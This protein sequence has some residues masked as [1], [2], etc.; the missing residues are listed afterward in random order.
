[1]SPFQRRSGASLS[2]K[3]L[4][5]YVTG[6][7]WRCKPLVAIPGSRPSRPCAPPAAPFFPMAGSV[8]VPPSPPSLLRFKLPYQH[9]QSWLTTGPSSTEQA[10]ARAV[11][12][13]AARHPRRRNSAT[14]VLHTEALY[15]SIRLPRTAVRYRYWYGKTPSLTYW[16]FTHLAP[17]PGFRR[18]P[19]VHPP[20]RARVARCIPFGGEV[21]YLKTIKNRIN[22]AMNLTCLGTIRRRKAEEEGQ[23]G[24]VR[25]YRRRRRR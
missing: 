11:R 22:W 1:M 20:S 21:Y 18:R 4:P 15:C 9:L 3:S 13:A 19:G 23:G 10:L 2:S 24:G 14:W 5:T 25:R 12:P 16:V 7:A 6:H 17:I 8:S